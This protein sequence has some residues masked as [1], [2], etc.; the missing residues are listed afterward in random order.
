MS[1]QRDMVSNTNKAMTMCLLMILMSFSP[2]IQDAALEEIP[3][4]QFTAEES[5]GLTCPVNYDENSEACDRAQVQAE[6]F[7][8]TILSMFEDDNNLLNRV[9]EA[10]ESNDDAEMVSLVANAYADNKPE[11][12]SFDAE[13]ETDETLGRSSG[14]ALPWLAFGLAALLYCMMYPENCR[15]DDYYSSTGSHPDVPQTMSD[16]IQFD[17]SADALTEGNVDGM[18]ADVEN[19]LTDDG[20]VDDGTDARSPAIILPLSL[21]HI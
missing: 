1:I 15:D 8:A 10:H 16:R 2:M 20:T 6:A 14:R 12:Q 4:L 21:I 5:E 18:V 11:G 13:T 3:E 17:W 19:W 7:I 9:N